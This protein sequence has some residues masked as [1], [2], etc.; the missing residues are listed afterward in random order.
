MAVIISPAYANSAAYPLT[1]A[2]I[3]YKSILTTENT[4]AS[5]SQTN[6]PVDALSNPATYERWRPTTLPVTV[7][8]DAGQPVDADYI[9][10]AVHS[11]GAEGCTVTLQKSD[12]G[13]NWDDIETV[14]FNSD[15]AFML[16]FKNA[17][18]RYWRLYID[19]E[20]DL[21]FIGA[22]NIGE[23]LSMQRPVY[24]G[25]T[26]GKLNRSTEFKSN[27]SETGQFLGRSIVRKGYSE[28]FNWKN[29]SPQW[30]RQTFDPFVEA[31]RLTPFFIAWR[32]SKYPDEVLYAWTNDDIAPSNSG[33][34]ELMEVSIDVE[35]L[36]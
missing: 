27:K 33:T 16:M 34:R 22:L 2:R 9:G 4:T 13:S 14:E 30:Y 18:A 20:N 3:G 36:G 28:S 26:P 10:I 24:G 6:F 25:H 19:G 23:V 29:L 5:S 1:H 21:P 31:A 32:P 12:D 15:D 11:L 17:T 7:T 8:V 35:G